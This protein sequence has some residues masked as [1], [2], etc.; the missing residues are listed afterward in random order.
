MSSANRLNTQQ[1]TEDLTEAW[2]IDKEGQNTYKGKLSKIENVRKSLKL[3]LFIPYLH[4]NC[5][6]TR[7]NSSYAKI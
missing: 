5:C 7:F 4:S 3:S 6:S 2:I 1:D